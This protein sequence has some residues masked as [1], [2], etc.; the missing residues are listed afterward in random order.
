[1]TPETRLLSAIERWNIGIGLVLVLAAAMRYH[2]TPITVSVGLGALVAC[3]NFHVLRR[4]VE[5]MAVARGRS[6]LFFA[7]LLKL[8]VLGVVVWAILRLPGVHV[9]A[10]TV[11]LSIFLVSILIAATRAMLAPDPEAM[12]HG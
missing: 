10:F 4:L 1:M 3:T 9:I 5:R 7:L 6:L 11:G 12:R 2:S 8:L